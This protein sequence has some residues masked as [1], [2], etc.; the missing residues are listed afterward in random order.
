MEHRD[1]TVTLSQQEWRKCIL[2]MIK[3]LLLLDLGIQKCRIRAEPQ[4]A[5]KLLNTTAER[6]G[7]RDYGMVNP[8]LLPTLRAVVICSDTTVSSERGIID[9]YNGHRR[10]TEWGHGSLY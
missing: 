2:A 9:G 7:L 6:C 4:A 8:E 5:P 10:L 1:L 3:T